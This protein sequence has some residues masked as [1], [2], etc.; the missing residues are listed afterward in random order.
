MA[1]LAML[2]GISA[3]TIGFVAGAGVRYQVDF[4]PALV[5]LAVCGILGLERVLATKPAWRKVVRGGW[6]A[7]L[8]FSIVVSLLMTVRRY[9]EE[10]FRIGFG[11][12]QLGRPKEAMPYFS[13]SL[14]I[15]PNSATA[16]YYYA[17]DLVQVGCLAEAISQYEQV[18]QLDPGYPGAWEDLLHARQ[19]LKEQPAVP[20][21]QKSALM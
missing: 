10:Q 15:N 19:K 5:L 12:L 8:L 18:L 7:V 20:K 6:M 1:A 13:E 17:I 2:F 3:L 4:V 9:A 16:H 14:R 21:N 11:Q